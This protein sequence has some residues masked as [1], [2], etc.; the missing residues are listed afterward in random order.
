MSVDQKKDISIQIV[1][2]AYKPDLIAL[3]KSAGWWKPSYDM[4]HDFL[5]LIVKNS[6]IF[7]GA[8]YKEKLIG[9]GRALSDM[10]SDAYIQDVTVLEE[11]KGQGIGKKIVQVLIE[12][13]KE[14][15]VDW[16]GLVAEPGTETFYEDLGF[17]Q[18]L[19]HV[20]L[21]YKD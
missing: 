7:A 12:Q 13:L 11:F 20:P 9:M 8:F 3:Y 14:N 5:N 19:N 6:A 15:N 2:S 17:E 18:L 16:I 21:K 1:T 4:E 10:V